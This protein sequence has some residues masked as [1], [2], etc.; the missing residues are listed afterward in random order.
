MSHFSKYRLKNK[1]GQ[2]VLFPVFLFVSIAILLL[3][4]LPGVLQNI[5][6]QSSETIAEQFS[7]SG[8][9]SDQDKQSGF[10][11][12]SL[13]KTYFLKICFFSLILLIIIFVS[14][15]IY[16]VCKHILFVNNLNKLKLNNEDLSYK[17]LFNYDSIMTEFNF[18][19]EKQQKKLMKIDIAYTKIPGKI[20]EIMDICNEIQQI[21][22][23]YF[24]ENKDCLRKL[25]EI[26]RKLQF[27]ANYSSKYGL[28]LISNAKEFLS[29]Q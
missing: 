21:N 26:E 24:T 9:D 15:V 13:L 23:K 8:I 18:L 10:G 12:V 7:H 2:V 1:K 20:D 3:Y 6:S 28:Q 25:S 19:N 11:D 5:V 27:H 17:I 29:N 22:I 16:K 4:L 14:F